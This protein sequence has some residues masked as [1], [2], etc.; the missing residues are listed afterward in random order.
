VEVA[1]LRK[2]TTNAHL[3]Q[4]SATR[5]LSRNGGR[6]DHDYQIPRVILL[7]Q[8]RSRTTVSETAVAD[9]YLIKVETM[10]PTIT[11]TSK[12][13]R[14]TYPASKITAGCNLLERSI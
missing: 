7:P 10:D 4:W 3:T 1:D 8:L 14:E 11:G 2:T 5:K 9:L 13:K 12:N 6:G